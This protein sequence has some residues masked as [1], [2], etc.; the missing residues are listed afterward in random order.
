MTSVASSPSG[1]PL[2]LLV[3]AQ[4]LADQ[5]GRGRSV[6][7]KALGELYEHLG[8]DRWRQVMPAALTQ[9]RAE[10]DLNCEGRMAEAYIIAL[11]FWGPLALGMELGVVPLLWWLVRRAMRA[12]G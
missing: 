4:A 5:I 2:D 7:L 12:H 9:A 11:E 8:D 3:R 10:D 1:D 6:A